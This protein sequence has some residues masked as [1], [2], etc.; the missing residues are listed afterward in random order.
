MRVPPTVK[1]LGLTVGATLFYTWVG[2]LVPQKE[3]QPPEVVEM[4]QDMSTEQL[5]EIGQEIFE[6]KGICATCHTIGSSGALR[7]PDL[8]GI[9]IRAA[10][11]VPGM[12]QVEYLAQSL[13]EPNAH[14][15]PG[16][17][18]GM[19]E[20]DKPPIGLSDDEIRAVIAYLQTLGGEA[21][22]TMATALP[23][24]EGAEATSDVDPP[25]AGDAPPQ[26]TEDQGPGAAPSAADAV[27]EALVAGDTGQASSGGAGAALFTRYGCDD[28]HATEAGGELTLVGTGGSAQQLFVEIVDH[29]PPLE[30]TVAS[31][32]TLEEVRALARY[33]ASLGGGGA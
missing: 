10:D 25:G 14:I 21:T 26:T 27:G 20:I 8:D 5:V 9:A 11:Q 33:L 32:M 2:Q 24:A 12:G 18:P 1:I 15:V 31:R 19:P 22:M 6:G 28:C 13:Y 23:Y 4:S 30:G 17:A 7:F 16:F 3:V 29:D